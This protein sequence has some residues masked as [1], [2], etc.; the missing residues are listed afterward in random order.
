MKIALVGYGYWGPNIA[1]N[2][3]ISDKIDLA[4]ICDVSKE[5]LNKAKTIYGD[6]VQYY[7]DYHE[8]LDR[9]DIEGFA[10]ALKNDV[11]Q[12]IAED[13]LTS[14]KHLFI[15]KPLAKSVRDAVKLKELADAK[16]LILH[17]DHIMIFNPIV[18]KIKEI[19]DSGEL[20]ELVYF[21][22]SR[23]N[24]GPS[25]KEDVNA[26]WDLAVH[27]L[28]MIDH[29]SGGAQSEKV[30]AVG[31]SRFAEKEAL[32]YLTIQYDGFIA[33]LKSSWI[34][35]LKERQI[36]IGGTKKMI[37]FDELKMDKLMVYDKGV[38]YSKK[39]K[40]E[41]YGEYEVSIRN[42]DMYSPYIPEEDSLLNSIN[43]FADCVLNNMQS[44]AN[45]D[46]AIRVLSILEQA[47]KELTSE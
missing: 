15:E 25:I 22:S 2:A 14:G 28:A 3:M 44:L 13:I 37:V 47:D 27:D 12:K 33:M 8:L 21:D 7:E 35:P 34:S 39:K 46:Q 19:I 1:K 10:L 36:I 30:N 9:D 5:R 42:G 6:G 24:L 16:G 4:A 31:L 38:N 43:H 40:F 41:E 11:G 26:M 32:T 45:A 17:V 20:G 29:L 23:V 18:R